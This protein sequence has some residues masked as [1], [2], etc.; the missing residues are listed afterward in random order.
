[1]KILQNTWF[2]LEMLGVV[3]GMLGVEKWGAPL[4]DCFFLEKIGF[5]CGHVHG[6]RE[7]YVTLNH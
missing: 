2:F 6:H 5:V 3:S 7:E 4:D 1:M